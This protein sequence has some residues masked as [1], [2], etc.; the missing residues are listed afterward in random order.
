MPTA[1]PESGNPQCFQGG[2]EQ[3]LRLSRL[4]VRPRRMLPGPAQRG[5]GLP[6]ARQSAPARSPC[7]ER[8]GVI[9]AYLGPRA[10]L[11]GLP[12]LEWNLCSDNIPFMWRNYR[13]CNWA[14]AM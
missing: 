2:C 8:N 6:A 14:Q 12:L 9:W 3:A 11:P 1:Q 7:R 4:E 10:E 13:A 5:A